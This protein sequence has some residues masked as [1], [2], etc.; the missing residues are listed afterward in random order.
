LDVVAYTVT[1]RHLAQ[2][3]GAA[4]AELRYEMPELVSG[5]CNSQRLGSLGDAVAGKYLYTSLARQRVWI[6]P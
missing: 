6:Q 2:Q 5:I 4:I 3:V 1:R